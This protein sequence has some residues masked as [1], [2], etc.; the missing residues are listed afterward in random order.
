MSDTL[1]GFLAAELAMEGGVAMAEP[2]LEEED[3]EEDWRRADPLGPVFGM[4]AKMPGRRGGRRPLARRP[5]E[6]R[7]LWSC[8][9]QRRIRSWCGIPS[10]RNMQWR[11]CGRG[12]TLPPWWW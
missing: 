7:S 2:L 3:K 11:R 1:R 9:P 8:H 12:R 10:G 5:R 4:G 6:R